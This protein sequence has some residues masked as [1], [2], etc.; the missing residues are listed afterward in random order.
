MERFFRSLKNEWVP[1]TG[2]INFSEAAHAI[3]DYSPGLQVGCMGEWNGTN[4]RQGDHNNTG[5]AGATAVDCVGC[6]GGQPVRMVSTLKGTPLRTGQ[7]QGTV[8]LFVS[9]P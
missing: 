2:Y 8:V 5:S 4:L 6:R 1:V 9:Y 7:F 3:T